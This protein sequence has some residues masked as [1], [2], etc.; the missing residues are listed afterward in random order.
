MEAMNLLAFE[1]ASH[2]KKLEEAFVFFVK[3]VS[4]IEVQVGK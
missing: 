1:E 4:S 2:E 3:N